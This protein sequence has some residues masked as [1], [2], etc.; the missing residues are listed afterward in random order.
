M[1]GS[2]I[3]DIACYLP[4]TV[5]LN[6]SLSQIYDGWTAEKILEKTGI[7][8]RRIAA[9]DETATDMAIAAARNLFAKGK[10]DRDDVDFLIFCTQAPD[11]VLPTSA[12][13]V[14]HALG[15]RKSTG[16]VD[17]NLGCSGFV[18][19]LAL[20]NGM[21]A[22]GAAGCVLILT[23]DTYSKFIHPLDKSVRTLFGDA[24]TAVAVTADDTASVGP[25]VFGTD[26]GGAKSLIV[27]T[28]GA[29]T[30]RSAETAVPATDSSGNVRSRD[31]LY[32]DGAAVLNFALREVPKAVDV[33]LE[34]AQVGR[35]QVDAFV[36]HQ[37]N[38]FMLEALRKKLGIP[39]SKLPVYYERVGNTVSSTIPLVLNEMLNAGTLRARRI[40]LV[41]FGVGLSWAACL[42]N[43]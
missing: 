22:S 15:L 17:I 11:Y 31:N 9:D 4:E 38:Q 28:G 36:L 18:Y 2:K 21:I 6:D 3:S 27:E 16:A 37:A 14:Q 20:A 23:A 13:L 43:T 30:P 8:E 1:N 25:F 34:K 10:V 35:D 32:M 5:L 26:G 19:A 24:A 40:M 29:R 12:C 39:T 41:G 42:L 7:I 33:L